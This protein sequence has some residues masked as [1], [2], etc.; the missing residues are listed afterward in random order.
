MKPMKR[1]IDG[2][3]YDTSTATEIGQWDNG[4]YPNDFYYI[5]ETLFLTQRGRWFLYAIGG[6]A[7]DYGVDDGDSR[8][9][10]KKIVPIDRAAALKWLEKAGL[11]EAI[12]T[13]FA[14]EIEPA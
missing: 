5:S 10:G 1:I 9:G 4:H 6:A 7:T 14:D 8:R 13:H 3:T 11:T 12:E 2:K